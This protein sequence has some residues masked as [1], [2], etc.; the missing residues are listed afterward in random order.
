[1]TTSPLAPVARPSGENA[2][3]QISARVDY[4][5]R[6]L[7]ELAM[8]WQADPDRLTK[9]EWLADQQGVPARFL[10]G[11]L[12]QL[13]KSGFV[14]SQR[15]SEGGYRLARPPD[16]IT[17]AD[18]VRVL[19]G[20]L[21]AVRNAAPEQAV[22]RGPATHLR[23]VWVAARAAIRSVL[24]S[25]TLADIVSGSLPE[26]VADLLSTPGVWDRRA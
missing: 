22:Y 5:M 15:G 24:E 23:D 13:R 1:M 6:A 18:I 21:G 3:M 16:Q 4:A 12:S 7:T 20:P 10:E 9:G 2:T 8:V 17:V 25:V 26:G 14:A 11:I 19:D